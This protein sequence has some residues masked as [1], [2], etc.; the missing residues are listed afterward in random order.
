MEALSW[1]GGCLLEV[2]YVSKCF[3]YIF[4][5]SCSNTMS[6]ERCKSTNSSSNKMWTNFRVTTINVLPY[7]LIRIIVTPIL[8]CI[9]LVLFRLT[10]LLM[11]GLTWFYFLSLLKLLV[12]LKLIGISYY[13]HYYNYLNVSFILIL[14]TYYYLLFKQS[15]PTW[16]ALIQIVICLCFMPTRVR[17]LYSV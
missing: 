1:Q 17:L 3:K 12:L 2:G 11:I 7:N 9:I 15:F 4:L 8:R 10:G 14:T 13:R 6:Y 16:V 5:I